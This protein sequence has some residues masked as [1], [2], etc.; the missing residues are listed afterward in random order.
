MISLLRQG[1]AYALAGALTWWALTWAESQPLPVRAAEPV[2]LRV[3]PATEVAAA[4]PMRP[5]ET[6]PES[7][8][9]EVAQQDAAEEAPQESEASPAEPEPQSQQEPDPVPAEAPPEESG[10]RSGDEAAEGDSA[11]DAGEVSEDEPETES[12]EAPAADAEP[13]K[14]SVKSLASDRALLERAKSELT[15]EAKLGFSTV[16]DAAPEDQLAIARAFGE[17]VVLVP[18]RALD[19]TDASAESYRL[20][21]SGR[22]RAMAGRPPLERYRQYRDLFSYELAR[23]PAP[24][25]TLRTQVVRRDEVYLFAALV[26]ASE[27]AV[28]IGRRE[29]ALRATGVDL[30]DV[31]RFHMSYVPL[32]GGRFDLRVDEILLAGGER[33]RPAL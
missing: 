13:R 26:P 25:R 5:L 21:G 3:Q 10:S 28:V 18:R 24:I 11:P 12:E 2:T 22:V 1:A 20:D 6:P 33:V 16:F 27:W 32:G 4:Q 15:A 7:T 19:P 23:L 9:P 17:D 29:E 8:P 30:D 14:A 31:E